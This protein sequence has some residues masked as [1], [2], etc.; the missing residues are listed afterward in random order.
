MQVASYME[1]GIKIDPNLFLHPRH[2]TVDGR[3]L[4]GNEKQTVPWWRRRVVKKVVPISTIK[5][6]VLFHLFPRDSRWILRIVLMWVE[7]WH[8]FWDAQYFCEGSSFS[9]C[10]TTLQDVFGL[11][12]LVPLGIW[13]LFRSDVLGV[14]HFRKLPC[15]LKI[16]PWKRWLLCWKPPLSGSTLNFGAKFFGLEKWAV[17]GMTLDYE[18]NPEP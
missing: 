5:L 12:L 3:K 4:R 13:E 7:N 8:S 2:W 15:N 6:M 10:F 9:A 1:L 11:V 16:D 17:R 14:I 18:R